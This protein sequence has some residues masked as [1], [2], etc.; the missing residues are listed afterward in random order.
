MRLTMPIILD[1]TSLVVTATWSTARAVEVDRGLFCANLGPGFCPERIS[2]ASAV[3]D[4]CTASAL[5]DALE[6]LET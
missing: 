3:E 5:C 2:S 4:H 6:E 1:S